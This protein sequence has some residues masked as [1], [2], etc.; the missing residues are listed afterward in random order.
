MRMFQRPANQFR[1]RVLGRARPYAF[2]AAEPA[3]SSITDDLRI[4]ALTFAG[5]FLFMAIYLA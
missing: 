4:F 2:V 3:P 5:G 1:T